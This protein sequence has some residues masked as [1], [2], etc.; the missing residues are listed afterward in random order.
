MHSQL[1]TFE[2]GGKQ[3]VEGV[4]ASELRKIEVHSEENIKDCIWGVGD[5][6]NNKGIG[7]VQKDGVGASRY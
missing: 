2:M 1:E 3:K 6:N 5:V 7:P 4:N